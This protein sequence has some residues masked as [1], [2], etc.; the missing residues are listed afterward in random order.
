MSMNFI[1]MPMWYL[2]FL[3]VLILFIRMCILDT[4]KGIDFHLYQL[5]IG[6]VIATIPILNI[7]AAFLLIIDFIIQDAYPKFISIVI[8]KGKK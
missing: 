4:Y 6:L 1:F 8:L 7:I 2:P 5:V 3:I